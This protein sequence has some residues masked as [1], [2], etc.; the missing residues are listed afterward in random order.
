MDFIASKGRP[1]MKC[2]LERI[3]RDVIVVYFKVI[4]MDLP[5]RSERNLEKPW[6]TVCG[7]RIEP[8]IPQMLIILPQRWAN[9]YG[10]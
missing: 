10:S 9:R 7:P 2:A 3:W 8:V 4:C 6:Y 5:E 1:I